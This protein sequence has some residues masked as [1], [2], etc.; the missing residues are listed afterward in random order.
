MLLNAPLNLGLG[1]VL[2]AVPVIQQAV[3]STQAVV[4]ALGTGDPT[5]VVNAIQHGIADVSTKAIALGTAT[6]TAINTV[7]DQIAG[8]LD[9]P[10]PSSGTAA[11][12]T[13]SAVATTVAVTIARRPR[14]SSHPRH[15]L[16]QP[17]HQRRRTPARPPRHRSRPRRAARPQVQLT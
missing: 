13:T 15:L 11:N 2:A 5:N 16:R 9:Q 12:A 4:D 14:P 3:T 17:R 8:A 1:P 6:T 7:R 10:L